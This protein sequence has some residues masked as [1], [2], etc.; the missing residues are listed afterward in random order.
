LLLSRTEVHTCSQSRATV[1]GALSLSMT[2]LGA[3]MPDSSTTRDVGL[4]TEQASALLEQFG[5]N[6]PLPPQKRNPLRDLLRRFANPLVAILL[7]A[8]VASAF[9][10]DFI[11]ASL[12]LCRG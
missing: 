3:D 2:T 5:P 9:G 4:T 1:T 12:V 10:G 8:S 7:L 6:D 11:N